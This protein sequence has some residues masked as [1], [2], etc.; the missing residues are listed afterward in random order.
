MKRALRL[1]LLLSTLLPTVAA[2]ERPVPPATR[3]PAPL[4]DLNSATEAELEALPGVGVAYAAKIIAGR[5]YA[6]KRQ[7]LSRKIVPRATYSKIRNL[8]IA[9]QPDDK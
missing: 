4:V 5:P 8:V 1:L 3:L 2:A 6:Q 9:K 7:L